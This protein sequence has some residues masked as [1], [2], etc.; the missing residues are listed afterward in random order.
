MPIDLQISIWPG[1]PYVF[2]LLP[3]GLISCHKG[4]LS[5]DAVQMEELPS[6]CKSVSC[7]IW[8]CF[9]SLLRN[10][11]FLSSISWALLPVLVT[12]SCT[13]MW[14]AKDS[15]RRWF[16][17]LQWEFGLSFCLILIQKTSVQMLWFFRSLAFW[18]MFHGH[19]CLPLHMAAA[20]S[21]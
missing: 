20:T 7:M 10:Y 15:W 6:N 17:L 14:A 16:K 2:P 12:G 18:F 5:S 13:T 4:L 3:K 1:Q 19:L 8:E 11:A 21:V 9:L